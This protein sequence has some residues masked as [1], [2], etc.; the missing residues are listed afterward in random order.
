MRMELAPLPAG[1]PEKFLLRSGDLLFARQ[2]LVREGAGKCSIVL[3]DP[4]PRTWE[5]HLIRARVERSIADPAFYYYWF[6]SH[7]GRAAVDTIIEQVAAAGIRGSDLARL[8]VPLPGLRQQQA[9]AGVLGA[10]DDKIESNRRIWVTT[11][12]LLEASRVRLAGAAEVTTATLG[13]LVAVNASTLKPGAP[14]ARLVYVDIA[15]VSPGTID[16]WQEMR[17][18][19]APSRARRGVSDGDVIFS[20][21]R[22]T[23]RS[24]SVILDP[25]PE[26]VVSTGFAVM[27]PRAIGTTFLLATV[28]DAEFVTYCE[29]ASQGSAYPAV[30]PDAMAKYAVRLPA[31][32]ELLHMESELMPVLRRG[33][34]ALTENFTLAALRDALLPELL[35]GRLRVREAEKVIEDVV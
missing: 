32:R 21:V 28:A 23:R 2:S 12:D 29:G 22:P 16:V 31:E 35:S 9:I 6:R 18:S 7:L 24:F 27:T 25:D 30:S 26:V 10:L 4:E 20:T 34:C 5:G 15:S 1:E 33:H 11:L 17:W 14:D 13:D 8:A 3:D 19:D